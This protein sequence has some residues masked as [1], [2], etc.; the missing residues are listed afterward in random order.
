MGE[1]GTALEYYSK[2]LEIKIKVHGQDDP[3]AANTLYNIAMMHGEQG[4]HDLE[5]KCYGRCVVIYA[6]AF[7]DAHSETADAREREAHAHAAAVPN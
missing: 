2:S 4:Q 3:V 7:G 5:A 1:N 6:N